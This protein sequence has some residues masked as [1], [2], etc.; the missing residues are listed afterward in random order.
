MV[1]ENPEASNAKSGPGAA[2]NVWLC[3]LIRHDNN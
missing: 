2:T 3:G 1:V